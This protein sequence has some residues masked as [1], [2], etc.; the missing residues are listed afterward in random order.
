MTPK[1]R[2]EYKERIATISQIANTLPMVN[3]RITIIP[4]KVS[5]LVHQE[6]V[7]TSA[8]IKEKVVVYINAVPGQPLSNN[9]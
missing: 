9:F 4:V 8:P 3:H 1:E 7:N 5:P 2:R 6:V